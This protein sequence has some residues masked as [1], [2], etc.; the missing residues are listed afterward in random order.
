MRYDNFKFVQINMKHLLYQQ[1]I[2]DHFKLI[3]IASMI[4]LIYQALFLLQHTNY[5]SSATRYNL[6]NS[7]DIYIMTIKRIYIAIFR[8]WGEKS[9]QLN[10]LELEPLTF[11][12]IAQ[13]H[14]HYATT[15]WWIAMDI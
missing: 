4:N 11:W 7:S 14:I 5:F 3:G 12:L 2:N 15:Y 13:R 6:R 10:I 8:L 1:T 9:L